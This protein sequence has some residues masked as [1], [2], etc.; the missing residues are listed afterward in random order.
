MN[1]WI[2]KLNITSED[3]IENKLK[4]KV[5]LK[6]FKIT[7]KENNEVYAQNYSSFP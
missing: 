6:G 4:R 5:S 2:Y 3:F 7:E 1:R